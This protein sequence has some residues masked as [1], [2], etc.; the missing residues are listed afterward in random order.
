M[1]GDF[2]LSTKN[3]LDILTA[4]KVIIKKCSNEI[5]SEDCVVVWKWAINFTP[6]PECAPPL[7]LEVWDLA[8]MSR[9]S[10]LITVTAP[11][12]VIGPQHCPD[13]MIEPFPISSWPPRVIC[14]NNEKISDLYQQIIHTVVGLAL[15]K[16]FLLDKI[17]LTHLLLEWSTI[18]WSFPP[19]E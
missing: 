16:N 1:F 8:T 12:W 5:K 3:R 11:D 10:G 14:V 17:S 15:Q 18:K 13:W 4:Q 6:R 2:L 7:V 19:D 9:L